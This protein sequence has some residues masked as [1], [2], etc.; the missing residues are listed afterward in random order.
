MPIL[1]RKIG[2]LGSVQHLYNSES[3]VMGTI[4]YEA[5]IG[6]VQIAQSCSLLQETNMVYH[7]RKFQ[8]ALNNSQ[9]GQ[10]DTQTDDCGA[11]H[12]HSCII[13]HKITG[14]YG[15]WSGMK[16]LTM[17]ALYTCC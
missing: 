7:V 6:G 8:H 2:L 4:P 11:S 3:N 10:I 17:C 13:C 9:M 1:E 14:Y 5:A 12:D 16:R 15:C